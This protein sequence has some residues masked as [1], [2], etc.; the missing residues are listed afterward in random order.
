[1]KHD[2]DWQ[3]V[4][5]RDV[6]PGQ[7]WFRQ[8]KRDET[9]G[10]CKLG[11]FQWAKVTGCPEGTVAIAP[12]FEVASVEKQF[13]WA[14]VSNFQAIWIQWAYRGCRKYTEI[15]TRTVESLRSGH[16]VLSSTL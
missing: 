16:L 10:E 15:L 12:R 6:S 3:P 5:I 13:Y 8:P 9:Y 7:I 14:P 4:L 1:M 11:G 2:D